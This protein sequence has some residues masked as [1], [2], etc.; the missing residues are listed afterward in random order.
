MATWSTN[1]G[2]GVPTR[3]LHQDDQGCGQFYVH[4]WLGF[5]FD[6]LVALSL[7]VRL[8]LHVCHLLSPDETFPVCE[9][10]WLT[11][12]ILALAQSCHHRACPV[13]TLL[14]HLGVSDTSRRF[15]CALYQYRVSHCKVLKNTLFIL[16]S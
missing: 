2:L 3:K 12:L 8:D 13:R 10:W 11:M 5:S 1:T 4:V 9:L 6:V 14:G 16:L 15:C 7:S